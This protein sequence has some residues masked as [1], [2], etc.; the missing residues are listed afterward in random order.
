MASPAM[1]AIGRRVGGPT[2]GSSRLSK[3]GP[4][5]RRSGT[6]DSTRSSILDPRQSAGL[7]EREELG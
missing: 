3:G 1:G 5:W 4:G 6:A 7:E 2:V